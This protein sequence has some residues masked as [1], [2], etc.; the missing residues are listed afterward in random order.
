MVDPDRRGRRRASEA[1]AQAEETI[2]PWFWG[3]IGLVMIA[4]FVAWV[5]AQAPRGSPRNPAGAAPLSKP[6]NQHY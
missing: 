2:M 3:A 1:E 6:I 4:V 5:L